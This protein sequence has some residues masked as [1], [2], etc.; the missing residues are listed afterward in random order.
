MAAPTQTFATITDLVN[1]INANVGPNGTRGITG[2]IMNNVLNGLTNFGANPPLIISCVIG[3][4][5][6]AGYNIISGS[7]TI[8]NAGFVNKNLEVTYGGLL[9]PDQN[10]GDGSMYY[11]K[12]FSSNTITFSTP[13]TNGYIKIKTV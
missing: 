4:P 13:L 3:T 2:Q 6:A 9:I 12:V 8:A 7:Y 10:P 1:Y 5:A 11:T